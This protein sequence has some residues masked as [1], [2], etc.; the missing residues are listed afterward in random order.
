MKYQW[1]VI[2]AGPAGIAAVGQLLDQGIKPADIVWIDPKFTVGDFGT[3][4][5]NVPSNTKVSLFHKFL[6]A[7]QSFEYKDCSENFALNTADPNETCHLSLMADPLQWVSNQLRKKVATIED[8]A[9]HLSLKERTWTVKLQNTSITARHV[10]L[11]VG[12]EARNLAFSKPDLIP[13]QAGMDSQRINQY[14][15]KENTVAVFGSSHSAVLVLRNLVEN[16]VQRIINFYRSPLRYAVY[17]DDW[18]LFDD[19]GLKGPTALWA[20]ENIDGKLP[21]NLERVYSN[22]ENIEHYL[23][24]CD[25][26]VY[27]VGFDRR[28]LPVIDG[29]GHVEYIEECGIIAPGLF[30]FGIAF[31]EGKY[32][33][34]GMYEY[35]VGLWKF[36]DYLKRVLPV[37]LKYSP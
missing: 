12:A 13:L 35:R 2:G 32:N 7:A 27:A 34:F 26:V 24:Q 9:E 4:W 31:P 22:E 15:S 33:L 8:V 18:I 29:V 36:M 11:A 5:R 37:W 25:K 1:A 23:P 10:I 16:G 20:K 30:G 6:H 28:S 14:C 21:A 3:I 17:L 19:S